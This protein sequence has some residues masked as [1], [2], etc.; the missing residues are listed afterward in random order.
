LL[1]GSLLALATV[2]DHHHCWDKASCLAAIDAV[3]GNFTS[4]APRWLHRGLQATRLYVLTDME[5]TS[6]P[7]G[8][9]SRQKT[10]P[11]SKDWC[12]NNGA[13]EFIPIHVGTI[14]PNQTV[15]LNLEGRGYKACYTTMEVSFQA[16]GDNKWG[17]IHFKRPAPR[18]LLCGD[19]YGVGTKFSH[20]SLAISVAHSVVKKMHVNMTFKPHELD[21]IKRNGVNLFIAPCGVAG[22]ISSILN[23]VKL[24]KGLEE[25][26]TRAN[27][28]FLVAR[29][30]FDKFEP[31]GKL[32][33][34]D[35]SLIQSGDNLQ[36]IIIITIYQSI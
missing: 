7:D 16:H 1:C 19:Y 36:A 23:T 13:F 35:L 29:G 27:Q 10:P 22:T 15:R 2:D 18:S 34:L 6:L 11:S 33:P 8:G 3:E 4:R 32:T 5:A 14:F 25:A 26:V 12:P 21:D 30:L 28:D 17:Y 20:N 31:F 24:F 9:S